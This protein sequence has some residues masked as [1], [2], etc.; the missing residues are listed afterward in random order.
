MLGCQ[1]GY[2]HDVSALEDDT[3]TGAVSSLGINET[4]RET[5]YGA[6]GSRGD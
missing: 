2:A 4:L 1:S 3:G 6:V 5:L